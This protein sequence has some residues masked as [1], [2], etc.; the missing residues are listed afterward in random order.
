MPLYGLSDLFT[1]TLSHFIED[2]LFVAIVP[3][4]AFK[5]GEQ[6]FTVEQP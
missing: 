4:G 2:K 1:R 6:L 5:F 3:V